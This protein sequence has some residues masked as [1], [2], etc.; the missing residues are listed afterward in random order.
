[1]AA[2]HRRASSI[3]R[4]ICST[5]TKGRTASCTTTNSVSAGICFERL[6]DRTLPRISA[7]HDKHLLLELLF[8]NTQLETLDYIRA[9]G[10]DNVGDQ[11]ASG[12]APQA[13]NHDGDAVQ[14]QELLGHL[15][16]HARAETCSGKNGGNRTHRKN[17]VRLKRSADGLSRVAE[18]KVYLK[19]RLEEKSRRV[20]MRIRHVP[21]A[22]RVAP[23]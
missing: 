13:V 14:F 10:H 17:A 7:L 5:V 1:M 21:G 15:V 8:A 19:V 2:L 6:A 22:A 18:R 23:G 20:G 9:R 11:R 12:N 3:T 16:A 4:V